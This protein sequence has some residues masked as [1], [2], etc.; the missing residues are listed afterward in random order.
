MANGNPIIVETNTLQ[1]SEEGAHYRPADIFRSVDSWRTVA[2]GKGIEVSP[3]VT[4]TVR[5]RMLG[6]LMSQTADILDRNIGAPADLELGCRLALGFKQG[7]LDIMRAIGPAE[8]ARIAERMQHDRPGMPLPRNAPETYQNFRRHVLVDDVRGVKVLTIRRPDAMNALHDELTDEL[9]SAI[10]EYEND[11]ATRGFVITG[12]GMRAFCAG[13]DIGRFPRMLGDAEASVQYARDCSRL[14]VHLDRMSKPVVA[15]LNGMA[16]GG[17]LEL[18]LRCH[19][20]VAMRNAWMQ[21]PEITLGIVPGIGAMVVPY[22][23]W[24]NAAA[25]FTAMLRRAER[26]KATMAHSLGMIDAL[27]DD[28]AQLID[29]A[30][31]CVDR[32]AGN[33]VRPADGR[34]ALPSFAMTDPVAANGQVLSAEVIG[35]LERAISEAAAAS[36]FSD[37]LEI[38]YRAFGASA[39]TKA[40]REGIDSFLQR[41]TPDFSKT[42]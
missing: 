10:C 21:L 22:R 26:L 23:R 11:S 30:I 40:A 8:L 33:I 1:M 6:V 28:A 4:A 42:G 25:T 36:T 9:L 18:A 16:L 15:A 17:G 41:R 34:I 12:Y 13:A 27:S 2:P 31:A 20:I 39:C 7:P 35:I 19:A 3:S 14:L 29:A 32:L 37:A 38:G 5:D 24:P